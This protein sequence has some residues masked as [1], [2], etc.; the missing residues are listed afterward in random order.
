[1]MIVA[2]W[3]MESREPASKLIFLYLRLLNSDL[4]H[5]NGG[6]AWQFREGLDEPDQATRGAACSIIWR[7][8]ASICSDGTLPGRN[9]TFSPAYRA[10]SSRLRPSTRTGTEG[11][12][13]VNSATK[14]GLPR[15]G[16]LSPT[17]T[18]PSRSTNRG[19]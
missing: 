13:D 17:T 15:P 14:A 8:T 7:L 1:M 4:A 6:G 16:R 18:R 9:R 3:L 2:R 11:S 10:A 5:T 12:R 19:S